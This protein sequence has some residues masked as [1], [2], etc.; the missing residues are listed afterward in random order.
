MAVIVSSAVNVSAKNFTGSDV[1]VVVVKTAGYNPQQG[2]PGTGT[3]ASV[4][5]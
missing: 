2:T 4:I 1:H 3:I 5:C